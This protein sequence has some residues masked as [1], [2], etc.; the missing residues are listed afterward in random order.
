[1]QF[2][3]QAGPT[4][5]PMRP[6]WSSNFCNSC[7]LFVV[8]GSKHC[9]EPEVSVDAAWKRKL[10]I[11]S[12]SEPYGCKV[13][14]TSWDSWARVCWKCINANSCHEYLCVYEKTATWKMLFAISMYYSIVCCPCRVALMLLL[15]HTLDQTWLVENPAQ[16]CILLHP[17]LRWA[18]ETIQGAGS[19]DP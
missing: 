1:M 16:S 3:V 17:W 18:L 15:L 7:G 2:W 14:G 10:S 19:K 12:L 8:V 11:C 13:G 9:H 4:A 5:M 6:I